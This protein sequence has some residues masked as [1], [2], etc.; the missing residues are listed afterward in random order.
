[1]P[2]FRH[3]GFTTL[4]CGCLVGRYRDLA[5]DRKVD[6]IEEKGIRCWSSDHQRNQRAS[7]GLAGDDATD[8][9]TVPEA[10]HA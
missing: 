9:P 4:S 3:V 5:I 10:A 7:T 8:A 6:Y 2:L 1:M